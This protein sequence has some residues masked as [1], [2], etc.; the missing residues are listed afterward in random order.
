MSLSIVRMARSF[1]VGWLFPVDESL[2]PSNYQVP[3]SLS[4]NLGTTLTLPT[5]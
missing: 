5:S 2:S 3:H 1:A 4:T